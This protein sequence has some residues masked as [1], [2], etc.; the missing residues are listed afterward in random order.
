MQN[1]E[2]AGI[3]ES[4]GSQSRSAGDHTRNPGGLDVRVNRP[5][6]TAVARGA[7]LRDWMVRVLR[8]LRG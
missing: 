8:D 4:H 1:A 6:L 3:A 2:I 5:A 7:R